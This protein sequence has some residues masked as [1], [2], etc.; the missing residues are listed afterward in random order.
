MNDRPETGFFV[1]LWHSATPELEATFKNGFENSR[2]LMESIDEI[3]HQ[4]QQNGLEPEIFLDMRP[5]PKAHLCNNEE[6]VWDLQD[7]IN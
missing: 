7:I 5:P 2:S 4:R 6:K 3:Y 1:G